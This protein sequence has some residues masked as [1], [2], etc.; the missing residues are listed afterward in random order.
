MMIP[1]RDR[2]GKRMDGFIAVHR[3][4]YDAIFIADGQRAIEKDLI[5]RNVPLP[6]YGRIDR[7]M[8][9]LVRRIGADYKMPSTESYSLTFFWEEGAGCRSRSLNHHRRAVDG[10]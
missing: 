2:S 8:A 7:K 6:A 4:S 5:R 3:S 10:C 1:S 9:T